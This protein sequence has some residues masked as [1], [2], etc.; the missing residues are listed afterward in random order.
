MIGGILLSILAAWGALCAVWAVFGW[1]LPGSGRVTVILLCPET[2]PE[3]VIA[4]CRWLL[5]LGLL[6]GRLIVT[7]N[8]V[9]CPVVNP[10]GNL[11]ICGLEDLPA[12]LELEREL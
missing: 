10:D 1:L 4:R 2:D 11:E 7:G 5:G 9:P 8:R 12:R 3:P 6:R